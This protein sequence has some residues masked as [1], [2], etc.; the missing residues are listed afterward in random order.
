MIQTNCDSNLPRKP[1]PAAWANH[2]RA[3][4]LPPINHEYEPVSKVDNIKKFNCFVPWGNNRTAMKKLPC[5][6]S[7]CMSIEPAKMMGCENR[8]VTG[9]FDE[10]NHGQGLVQYRE[11][12]KPKKK[13]KFELSWADREKQKKSVT[14]EILR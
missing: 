12:E 5:A 2:R 1:A 13:I 9:F 4:V 10:K 8:A 3:I 6:R 14:Q 11:K 7:C